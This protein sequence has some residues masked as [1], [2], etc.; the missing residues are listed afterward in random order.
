MFGSVRVPFFLSLPG[1]QTLNMSSNSLKL[2]PAAVNN[3]TK[4][5]TLRLDSN[6]IEV[7]VLCAP[8]V[9]LCRVG[10][11]GAPFYAADLFLTALGDAPTPKHS[12]RV[13]LKSTQKDACARR[14]YWSK[15]TL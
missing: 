9:P 11:H 2:L 3:L 12:P 10:V 14:I 4:L 7:R 1:V 8:S 5:K 15:M 13:A 6:K